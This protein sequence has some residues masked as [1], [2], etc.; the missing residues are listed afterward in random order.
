MGEVLLKRRP[1]LYMSAH[2]IDFSRELLSFSLAD[3][4][5]SPQKSATSDNKSGLMVPLFTKHDF[6]KEKQWIIARGSCVSVAF[7]CISR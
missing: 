2:V 5:A 4:Q 7:A 3:Q 1:G 6:A